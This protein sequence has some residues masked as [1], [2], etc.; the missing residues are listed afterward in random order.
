LEI[1]NR[2]FPQALTRN[3]ALAKGLNTFGGKVTHEG[4]AAALN[5]PLERLEEVFLS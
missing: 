2:G 3:P 4:V 5:L 1:A